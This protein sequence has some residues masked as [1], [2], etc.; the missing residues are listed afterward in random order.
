MY[1]R[2]EH[3]SHLEMRYKRR[4]DMLQLKCT[5]CQCAFCFH[6]QVNNAYTRQTHEDG[7]A[8]LK[9]GGTDDSFTTAHKTGAIQIGLILYRGYM[10]I[11]Y[12]AYMRSSRTDGN[13]Q[14]RNRGCE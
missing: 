13:H 9:T 5:H 14:G 8:H 3:T 4:G 11:M 1:F 10:K 2:T 12:L 6:E 7:K